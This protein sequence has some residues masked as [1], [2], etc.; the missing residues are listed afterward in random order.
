MIPADH[1]DASGTGVAT[2]PQSQ[3]VTPTWQ[4]CA[5]SCHCLHRLHTHL[6]FHVRGNLKLLPLP[7]EWF[8]A[9]RPF[10]LLPRCYGRGW[11]AKP[12]AALAS[13]HDGGKTGPAGDSEA[14][15]VHVKNT[16]WGTRQPLSCTVS[17][18]GLR[19]IKCSFWLWSMA[20]T[21]LPPR[22]TFSHSDT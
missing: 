7:L 18:S 19:C 2:V 21:M 16:R 5:Q 17:D 13:L 12:Y 1:D 15:G 3:S 9:A 8:G 6:L 14:L 10:R 20:A 11:L 4:E 22:L